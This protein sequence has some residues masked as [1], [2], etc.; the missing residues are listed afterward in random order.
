VEGVVSLLAV[1][2]TA[3]DPPAPTVVGVASIQ[4]TDCA[5]CEGVCREDSAPVV[6]RQHRTEDLDYALSPPCGGD[7][8]PCWAAWGVHDTAVRPESWVHNLEH[9]GVVLLY[10]ADLPGDAREALVAF[11]DSLPPG[12]VLVTPWDGPMDLEGARVAAVAW[13][14]R[15]ML[16]CVDIAAITD[17]Y[18][19]WSGRAPEDTFAMP[20]AE[21]MDSGGAG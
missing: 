3:C 4:T 11:A 12:R 15:L 14:H 19:R 1:L 5:T 21:C 16:G 6:S 13:E 7:H 2:L 10:T 17:F 9:G 8:H 20:A 18:A